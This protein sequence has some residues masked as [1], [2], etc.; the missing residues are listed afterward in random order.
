MILADDFGKMFGKLCEYSRSI[1]ILDNIT[2]F[3]QIG[4]YYGN[5]CDLLNAELPFAAEF[6]HNVRPKELEGQVTV[7]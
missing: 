4:R 5:L 6:F 2:P 3:L 1:P 7:M